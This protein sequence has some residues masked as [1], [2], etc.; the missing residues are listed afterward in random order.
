MGGTKFYPVYAESS[1]W[2]TLL[3]TEVSFSICLLI[4]L[5]QLQEYRPECQRI[6]IY[7]AMFVCSPGADDMQIA[8]ATLSHTIHI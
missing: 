8:P 6:M 1:R 4:S 5:I 3:Y 7:C 2:N